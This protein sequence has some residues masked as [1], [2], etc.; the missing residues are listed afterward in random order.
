MGHSSSSDTDFFGIV[1][2]ILQGDTLAPY[3]LIIWLDYLQWMSIDLIKK[4]GL[5]LKKIRSR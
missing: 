5:A 2:G 3:S 4:N 1:N